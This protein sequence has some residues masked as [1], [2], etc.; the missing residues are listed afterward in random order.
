MGAGRCGIV[1]QPAKHNKNNNN[2]NNNNN[3]IV[4]LDEL[5]GTTDHLTL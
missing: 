4:S 5:I 2:N 3:V 1:V